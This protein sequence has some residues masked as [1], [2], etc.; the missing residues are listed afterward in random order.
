MLKKTAAMKAAEGRVS[1]RK[2]D[3]TLRSEPKVES[4]IGECPSRLTGDARALFNF[5]REQLTV[6]GLDA[7]MDGPSLALACSALALVWKC[8]RKIARE[9]EV[10]RVPICAGIGNRRKIVGHREQRSKWVA[11]RIE[12]VKEFTRLAARFGLVGAT[13]RVGLALD[14]TGKGDDELVRLLTMPRPK[15]EG[16]TTPQ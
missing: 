4:G 6:S 16:E 5:Y 3:E 9:G 7:K 11:I 2:L 12:A 1:G 10:R 14:T 13:S 15:R 8:D